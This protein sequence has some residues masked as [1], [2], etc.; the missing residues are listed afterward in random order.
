LPQSRATVC[1]R[2]ER[3]ISRDSKV[4]PY[5]GTPRA[6][7]RVAELMREWVSGRTVVQ[8]LLAANVT[9]YVIAVALSGP[10]A[11]KLGGRGLFDLLGPRRDVS[12]FLGA[13]DPGAVVRDGEVWRLLTAAFLHA[14]VLHIGFNM[15][16]LRSIGP[17]LE[18][19]FGSFRFA[20]VYLGSALVGSLAC[21]AMHQGALGASGAIF[22]LIGAGW[23]HGRRRGGVWGAQV[24]RQFL[25]WAVS[26]IAFTFMMGGTVSVPGHLGGL[27]G[28]AAL[29][30]VL[31]PAAR[32]NSTRTRE[33][34]WLT[35]AGGTLLAG[36]PAAFAL[37]IVC[38][39]TAPSAASIPY[40]IGGFDRLDRWPLERLDLAEL[41]APG[42]EIDV[43]RAW[44]R[45]TA[46]DPDRLV[47]DGALGMNLTIAQ[48]QAEWARQPL[49]ALVEWATGS[50]RVTD[51]VEEPTRDEADQ[52]LDGESR[53]VENGDHL[54]FHVQRLG[55]DRLLLVRSRARADAPPEW[56]ALHGRVVRSFRRAD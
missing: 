35:L 48:E 33:N 49:S 42:F 37:A 7:S 24:R 8:L 17:L 45:R 47:L 56:R 25:S 36:V 20:I 13:L 34:R 15:S 32:R 14:G 5:C 29:G 40:R 26:G 38:G 44:E 53:F 28:G 46:R 16:W 1:D 22:G 6:G 43:P 41:G 9:M 31:S 51:L 55:E 27:A 21:V 2:C 10:E 3:L 23:A 39:L 19:E 11:L 50:K 52:Q 4:C 30:W 12:L 18:E 54:L